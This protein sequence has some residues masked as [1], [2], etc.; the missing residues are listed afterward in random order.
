MAENDNAEVR[1]NIAY[2]EWEAAE[3]K[4][5]GE[6]ARIFSCGEGGAF[7]NAGQLAEAY[8]KIERLAQGQ[9]QW[10]DAQRLQALS[11]LEAIR[12]QKVRSDAEKAAEL[13]RR[14]I[15]LYE[16]GHYSDSV[17]DGERDNSIDPIPTTFS[18]VDEKL[19]GGLIDCLYVFGGVPGVGKTDF[20]LQMAD[21]MAAAENSKSEPEHDFLFFSL[22]MRRKELF[23]RSVSRYSLRKSHELCGND[24]LAKFQTD[25]LAKLDKARFLQNPEYADKHMECLAEA[26]KAYADAVRGR[27]FIH[28]GKHYTVDEIRKEIEA[29]QAGIR[30]KR[31]PVIFVDHIQIVRPPDQYCTDKQHMDYV[32]TELKQLSTDY[33]APVIAVSI[34]N[35]QNCAAVLEAAAANGGEDEKDNNEGGERASGRS[36]KK[37]RHVMLSM[38]AFKESGMIEYTADGAWGMVKFGDNG[39]DGKKQHRFVELQLIKNRAGDQDTWVRFDYQPAYHTFTEVEDWHELR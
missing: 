8:E 18:Q 15:E 26:R 10:N 39:E 30:N 33:N 28:A 27:L 20:L 16:V 14:N 23:G 38:A 6:F 36:R 11:H 21:R 25:V 9:R 2:K 5:H 35:R 12:E 24:N 22:E 13:E 19:N 37:K 3:N 4:T 17:F 34:L 1:F 31:T 29:H 7:A 32:I